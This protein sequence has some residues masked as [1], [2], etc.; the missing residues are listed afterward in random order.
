MIND[1]VWI[2]DDLYAAYCDGADN[3]Q[4]IWGV[5]HR[6]AGIELSRWVRRLH[7]SM[8]IKD[9]EE[10]LLDID[11]VIMAEVERG[12]IVLNFGGFIYWT[13]SAILRKRRIEFE[14][15]SREI[16]MGDNL[17]LYNCSWPGCYVLVKE[18]RSYCGKHKIS[19]AREQMRKADAKA[20]QIPYEGALR[21]NADLYNTHRWRKLRAEVIREHPSCERCGATTRLTVHHIEPPRGDEELF[22]DKSNLVVLCFEHHNLVTQLETRHRIGDK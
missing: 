10:I 18:P 20:M 15:A 12:G 3:L 14:R 17:R 13:A 19:A 21:P 4:D 22:F 6:F 5:V 16:Q 7:I 2:I 1:G 9:F 11:C 8:P